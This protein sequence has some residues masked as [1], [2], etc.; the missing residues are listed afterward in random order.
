MKKLKLIRSVEISVLRVS[1]MKRWVRVEVQLDI[2]GRWSRTK[3]GRQQFMVLMGIGSL[4]TVPGRSMGNLL[5]VTLMM[6]SGL[7]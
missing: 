1:C 2:W 4:K 6:K 5:K 7:A 3:A